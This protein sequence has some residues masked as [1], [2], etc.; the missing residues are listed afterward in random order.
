MDYIDSLRILLAEK[1]DDSNAKAMSK[2]LRNLFPFFGLKSPVRRAVFK[3]FIKEYDW[4]QRDDL[5]LV[6]KSMWDQ[7][8][9]EFHHCGVELLTK[10]QKKLEKE[11]IA[12]IEYFILNNSWWDTVDFLAINISGNYFKSYPDQIQD[13]TQQWM[14]SE[15]IWLQRSAILFQLKYREATN[16]DLLLKYIKQVEGSKEFFINKAIGWILREISKREPKFVEDYVKNTN[17]ANLSK[18]EAMK[19]INKIK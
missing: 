12:Y 19:V 2:Y 17:L 3:N 15:N 14:D 6:V 8:E 10:F 11:D 9:R 13:T 16:K 4:P 7:K 18:R 1:S 5:M